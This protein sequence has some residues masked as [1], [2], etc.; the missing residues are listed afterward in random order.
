MTGLLAVIVVRTYLEFLLE[1]LGS[2][3]FFQAFYMSLIDYV[4]VSLSWL[5]LFFFLAAALKLTLGLPY[6]QILRSCLVIFPIICI[7]P[8]IDAIFPSGVQIA[9]S[10]DFSTFWHTYS[11]LFVPWQPMAQISP[12]VRVEVSFVLLMVGAYGWIMQCGFIRTCLAILAVYHIIFL[13]GYLP[14]IISAPSN[15]IFS[16]YVE[17]AL[18]PIR[19][20]THL[21]A[22]MYLPILSVLLLSVGWLNSRW[23]YSIWSSLRIERQSIYLGLLFLSFLL[24]SRNALLG[25]ELLNLYDLLRIIA[26]FLSISL[27]FFNATAINDLTDQVGDQISNPQRPL[28]TG[29]I[30]PAELAQMAQIALLGGLALALLVNEHFFFIALALAA[31]SHLYSAPPF[32]LKRFLG[33]AHAVLTLIAG[34]VILAG[35]AIIDG[36]QAFKNM[37][38]A[39]FISLTALF[40]VA[41]HLKDI[42]D[43]NADPLVGVTTLAG[44]WGKHRVYRVM[45]TAI[46]MTALCC[47]FFLGLGWI[48]PIAASL[49][50]WVL[51]WYLSDSEKC[52]LLTQGLV[53]ILVSGY[54]LRT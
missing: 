2:I 25:W 46:A 16:Q 21:Y 54:L 29:I 48:L 7:V 13:F 10:A 50:F 30:K 42:K 31:F 35:F 47:G 40:F 15:N 18:L 37:D 9:Y 3:S 4:H 22:L 43:T 1:P 17:Q 24:A 28:V 14:A 26:A 44:L 8:L 11:K 36:N 20:Q 5:S 6:S 41:A 12:G 52:L 27:L 38:F 49:V 34:S 51:S 45:T 32:R 33:V 53:L 39:Y 19:S 23:R